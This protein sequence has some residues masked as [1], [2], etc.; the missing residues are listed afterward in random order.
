MALDVIVFN[1]GW[2]SVGNLLCLKFELSSTH[3]Q[4]TELHMIPL[5]QI[6]FFFFSKPDENQLSLY[7]N[8]NQHTN[9]D[10][11]CRLS[12]IDSRYTNKIKFTLVFWAAKRR[13]QT[14][15]D[16]GLRLFLGST[17]EQRVLERLRK[18]EKAQ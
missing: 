1:I 17:V 18:K 11:I 12:S 16:L 10:L 4:Y 6:N 7:M 5:N 13:C 3:T 8:Y 14:V 15:S 9:S 2:N